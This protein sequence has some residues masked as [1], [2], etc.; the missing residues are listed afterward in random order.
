MPATAYPRDY[1]SSCKCKLG[2]N[3]TD[4]RITLLPEKAVYGTD[5]VRG[6]YANISSE[7]YLIGH[8]SRD[9]LRWNDTTLQ[10]LYLFRCQTSDGSQY[11]AQVEQE[12]APNIEKISYLPL[13]NKTIINWAIVSFQVPPNATA[14][15]ATGFA[16]A[17]NDTCGTDAGGNRYSCRIDGVTDT[18]DKWSGYI[19]VLTRSDF[20]NKK[21]I[22]INE[23]MKRL[24]ELATFIAAIALVFPI[25]LRYLDVND[26]IKRKRFE[27]IYAPLLSILRRVDKSK[28]YKK[29][30]DKINAIFDEHYSTLP[31]ELVT[32]WKEIV[33]NKSKQKSTRKALSELIKLVDIQYDKTANKWLAYYGEK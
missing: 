1:N 2:L 12:A 18:F 27:T 14:C 9:D 20:F 33:D 21:Q 22:E 11:L 31:P 16:Y 3:A 32:K 25:L 26:E 29:Q 24:T 10:V 15:S 7:A 17:I 28:L 19:E 23:S 13:S 5:M 6:T 30:F 4:Y 8:V